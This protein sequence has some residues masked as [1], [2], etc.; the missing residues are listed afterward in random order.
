MKYIVGFDLGTHQTKICIQDVTVPTE[1]TFEFFNFKDLNEKLSFVLPSVVQINMDETVSYGYVD[2]QVCLK[3]NSDI[4]SLAPVLRL[5]EVP[6]APILPT[7]IQVTYSEKPVF[8]PW[9]DSLL[10]LKGEKT[11]LDLWEEE[12]RRLDKKAYGLLKKRQ[13]K[14][15]RDYNNLCA[16]IFQKNQ[17]MIIEYQKLLSDWKKEQQSNVLHFRYF[18]LK[19]FTGLGM[20][21]SK[22]FTAEEITIW[23]ITYILLL[24]RDKLGEDTFTVK[25]GIPIGGEDNSQNKRIKQKAYQLYIS[26]YKLSGKYKNTKEYLEE[27]YK[28]LHRK[29]QIIPLPNKDVIGEYYF[30][31]LPESFAGLIAVTQKKKLGKGFHIL[32]DIGG[33]TTD[34]G[35]FYVNQNTNLPDVIR[36]LSFPKGLNFIFEKAQEKNGNLS[37]KELQELFFQDCDQDLFSDGI[38][39]YTKELDKSGKTIFDELYRVFIELK[40]QHKKTNSDLNRALDNQPIIYSGGGAIY[41]IL[42]ISIYSLRDI[43]RIDKDMLSI[44]NLKNK[45]KIPNKLYPVLAVSYGLAIYEKGFKEIEFSNVKDVFRNMSQSSANNHC[46]EY[47]VVDT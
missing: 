25:F 36:L 6:P 45:C 7:K 30:D 21:N 42:H 47:G 28:E 5:I 32:V 46:D 17:T 16:S 22:N 27:N 33:G 9:R 24:L 35:L 1:K 40:D 14:Q 15:L 23:Y 41:S 8:D 4:T 34:M 18:K 39:E 13:E 38:D 31:D 11:S 10:K 20:W 43:R 26:A 29:T 19:A 12:C 44:G 3:L 37:L 2:E